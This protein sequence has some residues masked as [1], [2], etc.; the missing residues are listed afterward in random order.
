[1]EDQDKSFFWMII[2]T[3]LAL[4]AGIV[5]AVVEKQDISNY[6]AKPVQQY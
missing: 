3:S 1:M 6:E 2:I 5:F 4:V